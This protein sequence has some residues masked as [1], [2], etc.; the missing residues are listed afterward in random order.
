MQAIHCD[1]QEGICASATRHAKFAGASA[2]P[3]IVPIL[4]V[5]WGV[6]AL[7]GCGSAG[8]PAPDHLDAIQHI[9]FI[10]CENHTFDN[11][12]GTFPGA[13]G[14]TMPRSPSPRT[15]RRATSA[16]IGG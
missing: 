7:A 15:T 16:Q 14:M 10:I 9:V 3:L 13:N 4:S 8:T 1:C 11:Y 6:W 5:I 12:F 2:L